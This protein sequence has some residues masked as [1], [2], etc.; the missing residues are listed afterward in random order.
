MHDDMERVSEISDPVDRAKAAI[1]LMARYQ[2]R[3]NELSR[4]RREAI[5]EAQA[6]GMTQAEIATRLG[7]SRGRVGQLASA[8]PP[9]ERAFFGT[10]MVTVSVAGMYEAGKGP[11]QNPS[12]VITREDL[13]NFEH[14]RKL[15]VGMK[16]DAQ[17]E[18]IPPTGIVNL[19][20]DN[21]VVICGPRRSPIVAQVLEGDDSL[22]FAKDTAWHLVDQ[23]AGKVYR[24]PF[25][26]DG[27]DGD[28]GY[29]GRLPR[30]DG[31]GTFL[32]IAGIHAIGA[33]G[34]VHFL[35]NNLAELYREVRTRRFSTLISC[36]YDPQTL[37]V[38]ESRRVT[39]L[40]RHEG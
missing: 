11:D 36:R 3:V 1:D 13:N 7:V 22:R 30:L 26:E 25:D 31:K 9:P 29:L 38:L 14:L 20:R 15:V 21:H 5:E 32:Y 17:Y 4:I 35:E 28:V 19:N 24:S 34:V 33:S 23:V 16:L 10:D 39:P 37:E 2:S 12:E 27:S 6:A 18:V 40:Y 8:G